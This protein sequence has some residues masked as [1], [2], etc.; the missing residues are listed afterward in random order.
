MNLQEIIQSIRASRSLHSDDHVKR[1][2]QE[3]KRVWYGRVSCEE[4]VR[5]RRESMRDIAGTARK[6]KKTADLADV[7][8]IFI[9]E[10]QD[11][12]SGD[13]PGYPGDQ[14]IAQ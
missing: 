7:L 8:A 9:K 5:E 4:Q 3:E 10:G 12:Y 1:L 11:E 13:N 14:V 2:R 6:A